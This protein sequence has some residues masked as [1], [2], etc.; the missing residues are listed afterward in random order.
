[1]KTYILAG[2]LAATFAM[3]APLQAQDTYPAGPITLVVPFAAGGQTDSAARVLADALQV[4]LGQPVVVENRTGAGGVVGT[5]SVATAPPDGYTLVIGGPSTFVTQ[6]LLSKEISYDAEADFAP[7]A[8]FAVAP[9]MFVVNSESPYNTLGDLI[10]QG[11]SE[12]LTYGSSGVGSSMHLG[13]EWFKSLTGTQAA[14]IPYRGS[15]QSLPA[16]LGGEIDFLIDPPITALPLV[17]D[18]QLR[19]LAVTA[20][21]DD[22]R[23]AEI[24]AMSDAGA[25]GYQ[26]MIWNSIMAPNGTPPAIV[27]KLESAIETILAKPEF[28][29]RLQQ[30]SLSARFIPSD[31][32]SAFLANERA[33]YGNVIEQN[34]I[35]LD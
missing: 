8:I 30:L 34:N 19:A 35:S 21:T 23:L 9:M 29:E 13:V 32:L 25:E 22:P 6:P 12:E 18:G 10:S 17:E 26:Q 1:M 4:E 28:A 20:L 3:T 31:E 11:Q 27:G 15:S 14:H 33:V 2:A 5:Q 7:I 24:P 16:L